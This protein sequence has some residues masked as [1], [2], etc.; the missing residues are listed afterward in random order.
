[1]GGDLRLVDG[2][3]GATFA[4]TLQAEPGPFTGLAPLD[5]LDEWLT[6]SLACPATTHQLLHRRR[7]RRRGLRESLAW[8][9]D[10][11][12]AGQRSRL[13]R[14]ATSSS[15]PLPT[16]TPRFCSTFV[17]VLRA[18]SAAASTSAAGLGTGD[19][20]DRSWRRT[21]SRGGT[22]GRS[23]DFYRSFLQPPSSSS[24]PTAG[25]TILQAS[26]QARSRL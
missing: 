22:Q 17:R 23:L 20:H 10:S 14:M 24:T 18:A 13:S 2:S 5:V 6:R 11:G 9:L 1:M 21:H 12:G 7:R 19:L 15:M 16:G 25:N 3:D 4:A 26:R 8:L